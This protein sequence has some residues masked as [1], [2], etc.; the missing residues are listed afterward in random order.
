MWLSC[1]PVFIEIIFHVIGKC[2]LQ[3]SDYLIAPC[4]KQINRR[5]VVDELMRVSY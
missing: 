1:I 2:R 3:N 4:Y 5:L